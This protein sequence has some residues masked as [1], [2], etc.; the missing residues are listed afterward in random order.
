VMMSATAIAQA[1]STTRPASSGGDYVSREEYD[2]LKRE[3]DEMRRELESM[4]RERSGVESAAPPASPS[5]SQADLDAA[6]A[7]IQEIK[8]DI[9]HYQH[10][11]S[12]FT[13]VGDATFS[14]FSQKG[15]PS[16]FSTIISPL[17]LWEPTDRILVEAAA[18]ISVATDNTNNS[19]TEVDLTIGNVSY[20]VNDYLVLGAGLFVVPFGQYH[21]HFD[22]P[23]INEFPDDPLAFDA[24]TPDSEVGAFAKGAVPFTVAGKG[25]KVTYDLYL[26]NGPNLITNDPTAAGSL[27][28][29]DFTDLNNNKAVGGR[30]GFL[31]VP[32]LECGYSFQTSKP[33]AGSF[34]HLSAILQAVDF[35]WRQDVDA[36]S[37]W[38][39]LRGEYA[40]SHVSRATYDPP[41]GPGPLTFTNNR[42]GGYVQLAYRPAY[43]ESQFLRNFEFAVRYDFLNTPLSS[44]GG[45]DEHRLSLGVD[46]WITP[47]TVLEAAYEFDRRKQNPSTSGLLIQLG[48]RL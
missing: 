26:A 20:L 34:E 2:K 38:F 43:V 37:G 24:I 31:P 40:W 39:D 18:D 28:F 6:N 42:E 12:R 17:A 10:T 48:L 46:Y 27:N 8:D 19:S 30:I 25:M 1:D 16:T 41:G 14:Y 44:P 15:S 3:Q 23:W 47:Q 22:P 9:A 36:L 7:S 4:K 32:N 29:D 13:I 35:N 11:D 45:D 33:G 5:A 21:N